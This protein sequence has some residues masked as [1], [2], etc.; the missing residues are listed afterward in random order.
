MRR[1][2]RAACPHEAGP[3]LSS[4]LS[5]LCALFVSTYRES[6]PREIRRGDSWMC[7]GESRGACG[8]VRYSRTISWGITKKEQRLYPA[9]SSGRA[10]Q[11][12]RTI[13]ARNSMLLIAS[14]AEE[15]GGRG[16][17]EHSQHT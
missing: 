5:Y 11:A 4:R 2:R 1:V 3:A 16:L 12:N 6:I 9:D 10:F 15:S 13:A 8:H 14:G 7:L 17:K